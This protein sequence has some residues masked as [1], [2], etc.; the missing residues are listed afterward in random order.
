M[1]S[2]LTCEDSWHECGEHEEEHAEEETSG[3]V[4]G[5][6]CVISDSEVEEADEDSDRQVRDETQ[7]SQSLKTK[8]KQNKHPDDVMLHV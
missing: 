3:V 2:A 8:T 4:E 1:T 7:T 5:F 6:R